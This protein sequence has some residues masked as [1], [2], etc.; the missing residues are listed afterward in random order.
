MHYGRKDN[1][2]TLTEL[3]IG[4]TVL[5]VVVFSLTGLFTSL[6]HSAVVAKQ[7]AVAS[8][9]ATNQMEYLKSLP[10]DDLAV[11][12]GSIVATNPLPASTTQTVNGTKYTIKTSVSYVD[13]SY[14]GCGSYPTQALKQTY[15]RNY[16]PP[17]GAPATDSN[18]A[19]Y[20]IANVTVYNSNSTQL[21]TVDTQI[22]ARVAE[23]ASTTGA[24]FVSVIDTTGSPVSGATVSIV[25]GV[26]GPVNVSDSTDANGIAIFYGLP[27]DTNNYDYIITASDSGY[28]TLATI[29]PSGVL[30]PT[31]PSQKIFTQQSSYVT[32]TIKLQGPDS[33]LLETTD[34]SGSPLANAKVYVKGGYKKYTLSTDTAYYYDNLSPSDTRPV[35]DSSGLAG[36]SNLVPGQYVFCGDTGGTSCAVGATT[37]YLVAALP[38][39]GNNPL[40]P[41]SVPIFDPANPPAT[42]YAYN[43]HSYYQKVRLMLSS[44]SS[45]P[46]INNFTPYDASLNGGAIGSFGFQVNG[47]NLP[48]SSTPASCGTTVKFVQGANTYSA[49]CSGTGGSQINCTVNLSGISAGTAQL[50][51]AANGLTLTLPASPQ[52]GGLSVTP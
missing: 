8:T 9:L 37:Y 15:C 32:L 4:L 46:R 27:P 49:S 21:A 42:T 3:V 20:K 25:N 14:D 41:V 44:N 6:T 1:G 35:T 18:P 52:M 29:P 17:S 31:Y 5:A 19:D 24:L 16:P 39:S 22:S 11:A 33:L 2:F 43:G 23:T 26:I 34:T 12:G 48:C 47:T 10:Y 30:Q 51:I 28:S 50:V 7:K 38:Y 36:L 45:F 13:D 40:N